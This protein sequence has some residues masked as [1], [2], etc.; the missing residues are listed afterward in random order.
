MVSKFVSYLKELRV[1]AVLIATVAAIVSKK[2]IKTEL[3]PEQLHWL[4]EAGVITAMAALAATPI[5]KV[6]PQKKSAKVLVVVMFLVFCAVVAIRASLTEELEIRGDNYRFLV[7]TGLTDF[8][9]LVEHNCLIGTRTQNLPKLPR[10]ELIKCAGEESIP[11][12]YG[13]SYRIVSIVYLVSYLVF[14]GIFVLLVG[15]AVQP[16]S[17]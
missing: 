11:E 4:S 7:G 13:S 1:G 2:V 16:Q 8:G 3:V 5:V 12:M 10:Y 17:R 9:K 15:E 14:L 6:E